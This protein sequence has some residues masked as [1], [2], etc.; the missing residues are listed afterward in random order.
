M[1]QF[2]FTGNMAAGKTTLMKQLSRVVK[3]PYWNADEV[4]RKAFQDPKNIQKIQELFPA[5]CLQK[6]NIDNSQIHKEIR[7]NPKKLKELEGF[8]HPI[9]KK[10]R[11]KYI[12]L[13]NRQGRKAVFLEIPL[14]YEILKGKIFKEKEVLIFR[15]PTYIRKIRFLNRKKNTSP[16]FT[17]LEEQQISIAK[18]KAKGGK[19]LYT[20]LSQALSF[21]NLLKAYKIG[22]RDVKNEYI[23]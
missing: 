14:F 11:E 22:R 19:L 7:Q 17:F 15:A 1:K 13:L 23:R 6:G 4:V 16:M 3:V 8:F 20:G 5:A 2:I 10:E 9:V 21:R 12:H 18:K